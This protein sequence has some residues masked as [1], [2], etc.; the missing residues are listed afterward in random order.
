ML[1]LV[2][3]QCLHSEGS[4]CL[5]LP[6]TTRRHG[7]GGGRPAAGC[8][9]GVLLDGAGKGLCTSVDMAAGQT[10]NLKACQDS[11]IRG[12][13]I[14]LLK[15]SPSAYAWHLSACCHWALTMCSGPP[16]LG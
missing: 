5:A 12:K 11:E 8:G 1:S 4:R 15:Q 9:N 13:P 10:H 16:V 7:S 3:L 14:V 2:P 6:L